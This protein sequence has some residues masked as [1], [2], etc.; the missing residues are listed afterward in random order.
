MQINSDPIYCNSF[1]TLNTSHLLESIS[2]FQMLHIS[3]DGVKY[4][5]SVSMK[6]IHGLNLPNQIV[7]HVRSEFLGFYN[8]TM[9]F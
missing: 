8:S 4:V 1:R 2:K 5:R 3:V 6:A 7:E 9:Y